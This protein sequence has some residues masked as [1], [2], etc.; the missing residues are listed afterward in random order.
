[1]NS[2][3]K[4]IPLDK[5]KYTAGVFDGPCVVQEKVDGSQ[6]SFGIEDGLPVVRSKNCLADGKQF[7]MV[8]DWV[9]QSADLLDPMYTYRGEAVTSPK[10]NTLR[11]DRIPANGV[12]LFDIYD[13]ENDRMLWPNELESEAH[14]LGLES[15]PCFDG[16]SIEAAM[17]LLDNDSCLGGTKIEGVVIKRYDLPD[18]AWHGMHDNREGFLKVK[19]VSAKFKEAHGADWKQRNP[20]N[21]DVI[22]NLVESYGT[23]ARLAKAVQHMRDDGRLTETLKDIG[24]LINE[25]SKDLGQ[26]C[27][28]EIK[29]A[30]W[31]HYGKQ[32]VSGV[33][34][35][36]PDYYKRELGIVGDAE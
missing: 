30:L 11:Y 22:C 29:E 31:K 20:G 18:P 33:A 27:K 5:G 16:A 35:M 8:I 15:V 7:Q 2:Y 19:L 34:R 36:M 25:V 26:E 17:R 14:R 32:V 3:G 23:E 21:K 9:A 28:E 4:V 13:A 12:I 6:V 24:P 10:H 1:M